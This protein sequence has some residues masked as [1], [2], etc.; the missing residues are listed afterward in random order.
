MRLNL[1]LLATDRGFPARDAPSR[2]RLWSESWSRTLGISGPERPA[3]IFYGISLLVS[4][5]LRAQ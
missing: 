5:V 4:S 3:V 2:Y 1:L